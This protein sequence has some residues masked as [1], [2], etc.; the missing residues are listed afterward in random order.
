MVR[1]STVLA[2]VNEVLPQRRPTGAPGLQR[3]G[4]HQLLPALPRAVRA[5]ADRRRSARRPQ[6]MLR[7]PDVSRA[8][9][10]RAQDPRHQR[11]RPRR[12]GLRLPLRRGPADDQRPRRRRRR[13]PRG[14]RRRRRGR[15]RRS[16]TTTPTSTSPCSPFD[17]GATARRCAFDRTA[18]AAATASRS[19]ATRRTGRTTCEPARIRAEQRL[20]S[21]D[22][23]GDGRGDP[24]GLLAARAGPA[25]QLRRPDRRLGRARSSAWCSR[26]RSPTT[27]PATR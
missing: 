16:S 11:L 19:S 3:R 27:T 21:P 7:D 10:E 20:R 25:R 13:R 12:R 15:R 22:I 14:D 4:R 5:R 8:G 26:R 6:R 2:K 1:S 24:R 9:G 23:Y 18:E 17:S